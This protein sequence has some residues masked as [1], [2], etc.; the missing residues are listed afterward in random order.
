MVNGVKTF[1]NDVHIPYKKCRSLQHFLASIIG[2]S[3]IKFVFNFA[4]LKF[5]L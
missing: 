2:K 5:I 4:E 3:I 1:F